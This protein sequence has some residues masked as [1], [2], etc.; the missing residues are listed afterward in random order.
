MYSRQ[1]W[2]FGET[3]GITVPCCVYQSIEYLSLCT[4]ITTWD[5]IA[6]L[7]RSMGDLTHNLLKGCSLLHLLLVVQS[8]FLAEF[9]RI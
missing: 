8:D 6:H 4:V 3:L 5:L 1:D 2:N 9:P 7:G